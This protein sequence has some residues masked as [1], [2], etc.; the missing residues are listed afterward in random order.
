MRRIVVPIHFLPVQMASEGARL[1]PAPR[2]DKAVV[3]EVPAMPGSFN[4]SEKE[5]FDFE[6][7]RALYRVGYDRVPDAD[8]WQVEVDSGPA[9]R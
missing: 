9:V 6:H 4:C 7:M 3:A 1:L 5:L 2:A 8:P